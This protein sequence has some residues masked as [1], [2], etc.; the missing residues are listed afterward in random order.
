MPTENA[1]SPSDKRQDELLYQS[2][3]T[4]VVRKFLQDEARTAVICKEFLGAEALKRQRH[5][6]RILERLS[7]CEGVPQLVSGPV[8]GNTIVMADSDCVQLV[9]AVCIKRLEPL[10]LLEFALRLT[11]IVATIH[12]VGIIHKDINPGNILIHSSDQSPLLVDF[13]IATTFAEEHP[14]FAHHHEI[15]GTLAYIAPE[16]T[17][18]TA[19]TVDQRADLYSL[20]ATL[21][22]LAVGHPPFESADPLQLIHDHTARRPK[23]P[24]LLD[25]RIPRQ[26]SDIMLRLLEKEPD[27]RYQSAEG[28][29][30]DLSRLSQN[31]QRGGGDA[32]QLGERDFPIRLSAPSRLVGRDAE[33]DLL[34]S[35]FESALNDQGRGVLVTGAPGIGKTALINELRPMVTARRGWFVTG[36][37]DQYRRDQSADAVRQ[38]L[39][40]LGRLLLAEPEEQL[41]VLRVHILRALGPNAGLIAALLPEFSTLLNI[42][43]ETATGDPVETEVR[44]RLTVLE[45]LRSIVSPSRPLVMVVDDL[46]W[47]GSVPIH[48]IESILMDG[49]VR[50]LLLVGAY[51]ESEV[52][53]T[54]PLATVLP[55][56]ERLGSAPLS[57]R[58]K[59]LP[60]VYLGVLL[61]EMLRLRPRDAA[62]LAEAVG[63]RTDGNPYDTVEM[64]NALRRDG[65]LVPGDDGWSWDPRTIRHYIGRGDVVDLLAA[66]MEMLPV[67]TRSLL[68]IMACLGGEVELDLLQAASGV[69]STALETYLTSALEDG[70]LIMEQTGSNAVRFRHDRVQQAA[71]HRMDPAARRILHLGIA[72]RLAAIPALGAEAA[73]QYLPA[74]ETVSDAEECRRVL[75]LFRDAATNLRLINYV[76]AERFL[77]A[78]I[79]L[80]VFAPDEKLLHITL[81]T[82]HHAALYSLARHDEADAVY[83]SIERRASDPRQLADAAGVQMNSLCNRGRHQEAV[84]LGLDLL[85]Q[86]G[87]EPPRDNN[88]GALKAQ[89]DVLYRWIAEDAQSEELRRSEATGPLVLSAARVANRMMAPAFFSN[90]SI[91]AWLILESQRL[92]AKHGPCAALVANISP[93]G[94]VT[95]ALR[96][97]FRTGYIAARRALAVG[98]SRGYEPET[99]WARFCF[100]LFAI[101]WFEPLEHV[102]QQAQRARE[103]LLHG[104]DLQFACFTHYAS[105]SAL[106]DCAPTLE[107]CAS[108]VEAA[109]T[110]AAR[111]GNDY[112]ASCFIAYRQLIKALR[113]ET[114]IVGRLGDATFNELEHLRTLGANPLAASV[115][116][117]NCALAAVLFDDADGL[118]QHAAAAMPLLPYVQGFYHTSTANL[119]QSITLAERA[120]AAAPEQ[121]TPLLA[122]LDRCREWIA[123]R[124]GDI[125]DNFLNL[126]NLVDAE[127]AWV[128]DDFRKAASAF[129]AAQ[130]E[131]TEH[132]RPWHQALIAERAG[133]FHLAYG[134]EHAGRNLLAEA[135]RRYEDWGATAKVLKLKRDHSFLRGDSATRRPNGPHRTSSVSAEAIDLLAVVRASQALS[136]ETSL[137]QLKRRVVELLGAMTGATTVLVVLREDNA[138][139]WFLPATADQSGELVSVEEAGARGLLPLSAFRYAERTQEPLLVEDATRDDRFAHDSYVAGLEQC[140]LMLVPILNQGISRAVLFLENRLSRGAFS[141]DRLDA[142]ML[143]AGQLTV[144]LDNARLYA[145]LEQKVADRTEAL[146]NSLALTRATLESTTDG[147][148][149]TDGNGKITGFNE[150]FLEMWR[151]PRQLTESDEEQP[152][153]EIGSRQLKDPQSFF[154]KVNDLYSDPELETFDLLEFEDGRVFERYSKPQRI[155]ERSAGRVWSFRDVTERKRIEDDLRQTQLSVERAVDA[156][157][158]LDPQARF[159]YVNEA[160]CKSVGYSREELLKLR[161]PDIA[162]AST[163]EKWPDLWKGSHLKDKFEDEHRSKD[164][165]TFPVEVTINRITFLD[166]EVACVYSRDITERKRAE[167]ELAHIHGRLLDLSR[168]A[169]MTEVATSVIHNVGNVLNSVNVSYSIIS[170]NI[171]GSSIEHVASVAALLRAQRDNIGSFLTT[172][173]QG[174]ELPGFICDLSEQLI[175]E[176]ETTLDELHQ[177][178]RNI[179]HIKQIVAMQQSYATVGGVRE[180]MTLESVVEDAIRF[181]QSGLDRHRIEIIRQFAQLPQVSIEKHKVL[182]IL[183]NLVRNAKHALTEAARADKRLIVRIAGDAQWLTVSVSDNGIGIATENLTRI[184]AHGFTTK[185]D[186]H[187]FGLH[188][189]VL[190][191]KEMGGRLSVLSDG[192]GTGATFTLELPNVLNGTS[193][194][195]SEFINALA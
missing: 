146:A 18:R 145:S 20:G 69:E 104:G 79:A 42:S 139:E 185:K 68:G 64:V 87:L 130:R 32:F 78:S 10:E 86:L 138:S 73:E 49:R 54:H 107:N 180:K 57:I 108:E 117:V 150:K 116:H 63:T 175:E 81:E 26:F 142:V 140:S 45:L 143:I 82:E 37:F 2:E 114:E 109:L 85:R 9:E 31:L 74:F 35:A 48:F 24:I 22:E 159:V 133:L 11:R 169:G 39:R 66:R 154:L 158:W 110:F 100:A 16:Q 111:T 183:V 5:E 189:G 160:A 126:L 14:G 28:L 36:K 166:R 21:Y 25:P 121:R 51:R 4:C 38:S 170:K 90:P 13:S 152:F 186:G 135:Y 125:P 188:S 67:E 190:A 131:F 115:F 120:R 194:D 113:G 43:P 59:N 127:R 62:R 93:V 163:M 52:D 56:W 177:L 102:V 179:E 182:Q 153:L 29:A 17:G 84:A 167:T 12:R 53:E 176:Q 3:Q 89:L 41:V 171:Q 147:I 55:R 148:L 128:V 118:T 75:S 137:F 19:R 72:R 193:S 156:V 97:D 70:L 162:P 105:I 106:L 164:G 44:L 112:I 173:P 101:P 99:S 50:G 71:Y 94:S 6:L 192:L 151:M 149:A 47:A 96:Q 8:S 129:D 174:K 161:L 91:F 30:R 165:R 1:A 58:L 95:I 144:S 178:G 132:Q 33:I 122:E 136:S 83:A 103:G 191:A 61:E 187:G 172:T 92:W 124:A 7:G 23:P 157:W 134:M 155:E 65:T 195:S 27:L 34:R 98:E 46:Q 123:H 168:Q 77:A 40:A 181:N 88:N 119:L 141:T 184:F 60:P 80:L 15:V 76:M